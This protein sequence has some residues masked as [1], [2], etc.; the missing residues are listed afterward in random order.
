VTL[1]RLT[2]IA[3]AEAVHAESGKTY[4]TVAEERAAANDAGDE[5]QQVANG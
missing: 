4:A 1:K 2:A 5:Q 3:K